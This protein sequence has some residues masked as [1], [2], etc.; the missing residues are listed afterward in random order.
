M[1]K[2]VFCG[3]EEHYFKGLNLIKN[4]GVVD[5]YCSEKCRKNALKLKRDKRKVK[6]TEAYKLTLKKTQ[7]DVAKQK[8][9]DDNFEKA[10]VESKALETK[11]EATKKAKK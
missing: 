4:D 8:V 11:K 7:S 5:Y 3:R 6:W 9:K 10:R 2:C 1:T